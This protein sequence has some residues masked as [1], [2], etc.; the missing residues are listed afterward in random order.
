MLLLLQLMTI[1]AIWPYA[2]GD[3]LITQLVTSVTKKKGSTAFLGCQIKTATLQNNLYIHWYRQQAGQPLK[4]ILCISSNE[5]VLHERDGDTTIKLS[6]D[7]L[8]FTRRLDRTVHISCRLSG[9]PLDNAIVHWY[10]HKEGEPLKRI[11]YGSS[12]KYKKDQPNP[13]LEADEKDDGVFYL[14]INNV[15]QSDEATYYCACW[16]FT[17][18][19]S[20]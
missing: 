8:S 4:R 16:D 13:R 9:V 5:N 11:L 14:I 2:N 15:I 1:A 19:A 20:Q 18:S 10:Q 17:V 6:Q 7:Q 12:K 3:I